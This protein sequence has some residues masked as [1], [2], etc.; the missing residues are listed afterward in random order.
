[1][2]LEKLSQ[3]SRHEALT[4]EPQEVLIIILR[5][6]CLAA[7]RAKFECVGPDGINE[8]AES[9]VLGSQARFAPPVPHK[10]QIC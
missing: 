7:L 3:I 4:K 5:C 8:S 9:R 10:V 1:M 6:R 2:E